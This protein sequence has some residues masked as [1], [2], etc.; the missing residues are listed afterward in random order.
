VGAVPEQLRTVPPVHNAVS[1]LP[2]TRTL[3]AAA[4]VL[5]IVT[6]LTVAWGVAM[7]RDMITFPARQMRATRPAGISVGP[8]VVFVEHFHVTGAQAWTVSYWKGVDDTRPEFPPVN[9][10]AWCRPYLLPG[11]DLDAHWPTTAPP[12]T[13]Y[14]VEASAF[15]AYGWP[16]PAL[17]MS[18]EL[19]EPVGAAYSWRSRGFVLVP[20]FRSPDR[21][22]PRAPL[23]L[24][25]LPLWIGLVVNTLTF[26]AAAFVLL[27]FVRRRQM[28]RRSR[29][30]RCAW[31]SYDMRATPPVAPC[32]ECGHARWREYPA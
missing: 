20:W 17:A 3:F 9:V 16:L 5:G 19:N 1:R 30:G 4:V 32:P 11:G 29:S 23:A 10:P 28:A 15:R 8:D 24:P 14:S 13:P 27:L 18:V 25:G 12:R 7:T 31:C 6:T 22:V 2:R 26:A 21:T